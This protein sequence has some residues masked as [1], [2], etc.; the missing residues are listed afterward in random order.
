MLRIMEQH[1]Y[2]NFYKNFL[3]APLADKKIVIYSLYWSLITRFC[4]LFLPFKFYRH[5]L[6]EMHVVAEND[7][8]DNVAI[9][10]ALHIKQLVLIVT[11]H[12]PW[13]SKCLVQDIVCKRLL[14]K[15]GIKTTLYLGAAT[16]AEKKL[17]AHA[18]LKCGNIVL[19]GRLGHKRFK[20]VNYYA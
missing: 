12:T 7:N 9:E 2:K 8:Y 16:T 5:F 18:W 4:L 13:A 11:S 1:F 10:K 6:G 14:Q 20:V 15:E 3:Q 17:D 19:T